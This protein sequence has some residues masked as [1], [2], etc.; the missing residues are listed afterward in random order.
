MG[1]PQ[2][3]SGAGLLSKERRLYFR[4]I[5][6]AAMN[7]RSLPRGPKGALGSLSFGPVEMR[8]AFKF[9]WL[10]TVAAG[11]LQSLCAQDLSPRAYLITPVQ[12]NVI[13]L[14]WS[15]YD[16]SIDFNGVVPATGATGTYSVPILACYH[17]F[18]LFGRSANVVASLPYG[19]GNFRGTV[20]GAGEHLYRSG[21]LDSVYR[22]S[23]NLKGGPAL[24]AQQFAK[25][26]QKVLL[27]LGQKCGSAKNFSGWKPQDRNFFPPRRHGEAT[28]SPTDHQKQMLGGM[29]LMCHHRT[30]RERT[31]GRWRDD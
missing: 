4:R 23:V 31:F 20:A 14:T 30:L 11:S 3:G 24:P 1:L 29:S 18:G 9:A 27:G 28:G 12:A 26:R 17:S 8:L 22:I 16:G 6:H 19:V 2:L 7:Q 15:F 10:A 5:E 25:W 21:L 13:T